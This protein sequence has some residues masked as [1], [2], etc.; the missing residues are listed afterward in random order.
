MHAFPLDEPGSK[1]H[2]YSVDSPYILVRETHDVQ[3]LLKLA[4]TWSAEINNE[5]SDLIVHEEQA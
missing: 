5:S 3:D 4:Q 1:L 2:G